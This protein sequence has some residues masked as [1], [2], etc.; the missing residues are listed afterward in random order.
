MF[1]GVNPGSL[2]SMGTT[3]TRQHFCALLTG[4]LQIQTLADLALAEP[5]PLQE[6]QTL[7]RKAGPCTSRWLLDGH[8]STKA[9]KLVSV[10]T[11]WRP[12]CF[13]RRTP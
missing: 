9:T 12:E 1:P 6:D 10:E 4:P 7:A 5:R 3:S 11:Q 2:E 13:P 8:R